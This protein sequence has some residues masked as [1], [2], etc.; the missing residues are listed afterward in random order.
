[1]NLVYQRYQDVN[2]DMPLK[3]NDQIYF[4]SYIIKIKDLISC[5]NG[6]QLDPE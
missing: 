2:L 4:A 1:M 6:K 3:L 5:K